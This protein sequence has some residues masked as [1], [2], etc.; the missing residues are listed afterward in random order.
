MVQCS[1]KIISDNQLYQWILTFTHTADHNSVGRSVFVPQK[2][3]SCHRI[4]WKCMND[5]MC[6][7]TAKEV[8]STF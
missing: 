6:S 5:S 8:G 7:R 1:K 2:Y 3:F 4:V